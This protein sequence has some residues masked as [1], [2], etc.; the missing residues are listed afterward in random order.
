MIDKTGHRVLYDDPDL[1]LGHVLDLQLH[2]FSNDVEEICDQAQKEEKM[3]LLLVNL[4][5]TWENVV[6]LIDPYK[7]G[8]SVNLLRMGDDDFEQLESDQLQ[9]Q[10]MMGSRFVKTFEKEV[11]HWNKTLRTVGD[12]MMILNVIQRTW[13]YLEPLFIGSPEVRRELPRTLNV[14]I[15]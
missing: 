8:S 9:V 11:L 14:F 6:F 3:E 2:E 7:D 13:S 1:E 10:T 15:R 12:V 4:K 5:M